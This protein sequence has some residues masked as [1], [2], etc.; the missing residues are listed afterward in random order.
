MQSNNIIRFPKT[1]PP[2]IALP[3][4]TQLETTKRREI[5]VQK[6]VDDLVVTALQKFYDNN[7][8]VKDT[9]FINDFTF[10]VETLKATLYRRLELGHPLHPIMDKAIEELNRASGD[11]EI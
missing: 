10:S 9:D 6:I 4:E 1:P 3:Q 7:F 11:F 2:D 8:D 5:F